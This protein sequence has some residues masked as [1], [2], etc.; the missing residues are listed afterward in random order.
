MRRPAVP[1]EVA[2]F[3]EGGP[4]WAQVRIEPRPA[5]SADALVREMPDEL[6][7]ALGDD[8]ALLREVYVAAAREARLRL[9]PTA[10]SRHAAGQRTS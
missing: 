3:W 2:R 10:A 7:A 5:G 4:A 8:V 6:R 9:D 1:D